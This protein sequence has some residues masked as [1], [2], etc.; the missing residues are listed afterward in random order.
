MLDSIL[1][2]VTLPAHL[3]GRPAPCDFFDARGTLLLRSGTPVSPRA[4]LDPQ[5]TRLYCT[6]VEARRLSPENPLAEL[7]ALADA[8]DG[9]GARASSDRLP[10]AS[11]FLRLARSLH[12]LWQQ[13]A[14]ACIGY[15][16]LT[17][18]GTPSACHAIRS[19]L[20]V[21]ELGAANGLPPDAM[22]HTIGAALT[23]NL[24]SMAL[25]DRLHG[26]V[27]LPDAASAAAI[28]AHPLESKRLLERIGGFP[29]EWLD[30]VAQH[31]ENVDGS[32]YPAGLGRSAIALGARMLRIA[33]LL[34][35]R[36]GGRR[37]RAPR[38]WILH[39]TRDPQRLIQHVFGADLD[40]L[41]PALVRQLMG[42]LGAFPPGSLVRLSNGELALVARRPADLQAGPREVW[43]FVGGHGRP[44]D[45]PRQRRLGPRECQIRSYAHDELPRLPACDWK[46]VWGYGH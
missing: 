38:Y 28:H 33:D 36:L 41:D 6:A 4:T 19:A 22:T 12:A 42:R 5:R 1:R 25:H 26:L 24:A 11:E 17:A 10:A 43:S 21:A 34:A 23:M 40:H 18:F 39:Q 44:L 30:A 31:H 7:H 20:F 3:T 2:P 32:G 45:T 35:A 16:R 27:N 14:D 8:L 46:R 37:G 15:A 13:D 29:G 9:L